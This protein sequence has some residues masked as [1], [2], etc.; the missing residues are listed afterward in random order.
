MYLIAFNK[1][2]LVLS[3]GSLEPTDVLVNVTFVDFS[4]TVMAQSVKSS[5]VRCN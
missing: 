5:L 3:T 4:E 2:I 1:A